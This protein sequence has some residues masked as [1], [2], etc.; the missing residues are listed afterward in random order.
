MKNAIASTGLLLVFSF[1]LTVAGQTQAT[2]QS[3]PSVKVGPALTDKANS[4]MPPATAKNQTQ[5]QS[6]GEG[7]VAVKA[8]QPSSA[9]V[10]EVDVDNDGTVES[11]AFLYDSQRGI[12]YAY[13]QDNFSCPNG[14][15]ESGSILEAVYGKS[16]HA[17]EPAGSGWYA[18][19][20]DAGQCNAQTAGTYGCRFDASGN[21][22]ECGA[23]AVDYNTGEAEVVAVQ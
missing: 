23:I 7:K 3:V 6:I 8:S 2:Q 15:P 14:K 1:A 19:S 10:E 18:V 13:R 22:T 11:T 21:P 4:P 17:G 20:L 5:K 12:L 16:N 9:W